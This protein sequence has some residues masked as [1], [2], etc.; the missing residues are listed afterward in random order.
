M[1]GLVVPVEGS[2]AGWIVT[3][4]QPIISPQLRRIRLF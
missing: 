1:R 4:R 3:N 2:I